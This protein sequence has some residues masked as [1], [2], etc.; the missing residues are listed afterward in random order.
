MVIFFNHV[1]RQTQFDQFLWFL[2]FLIKNGQTFKKMVLI[3]FLVGIKMYEISAYIL[4]FGFKKPKFYK[5]CKNFEIPRQI[6][7]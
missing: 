6:F 3:Y 7:P 4:N 5:K 2:A 1:L